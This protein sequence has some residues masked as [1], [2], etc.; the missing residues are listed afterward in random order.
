MK[1]VYYIYNNEAIASTTFLSILQKIEN[2]DVSRA[3]LI[4]PFLFEDSMA[5]ALK[6]LHVTPTY[7]LEQFMA[8]NPRLFVSFNK[9][10]LSLLPV[11]INS[12][13]ILENTGQIKIGKNITCTSLL[14]IDGN[15]SLGERFLVIEDAIPNLLFLLEQKTTVQLYKTL[16]VQL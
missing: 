2:L 3:C 1:E 4:L 14:N 5:R 16:N 8:E 10:Y 13:M 7:S 15:E 9:R 11:M 6:R 12:L